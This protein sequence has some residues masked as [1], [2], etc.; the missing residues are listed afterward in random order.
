MSASARDDKYNEYYKYEKAMDERFGQGNWSWG[1]QE[2]RMR[3]LRQVYEDGSLSIGLHVVLTDE[4]GTITG[5]LLCGMTLPK[6]DMLNAQDGSIINEEAL[7]DAY[8]YMV[9]EGKKH[10]TKWTKLIA[11]KP[12]DKNLRRLAMYAVKKGLAASA[13][14]AARILGS[15]RGVREITDA[16]AHFHVSGSGVEKK[17]VDLATKM[18]KDTGLSGNARE[19]VKQR[20]ARSSPDKEAVYRFVYDNMWEDVNFKALDEA[21]KKDIASHI[22][23]FLERKTERRKKRRT[24]KDGSS[25]AH[26]RAR[27]DR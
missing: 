22:R 20:L 18:A 1:D 26:R 10:G 8:G 5:D 7:S 13:Y 17:I 9:M 3:Y 6:W 12:A 15:K 27:R 24:S 21:D 14:R 4:G 25:Y 2:E 23:M 16:D 19:V 11:S